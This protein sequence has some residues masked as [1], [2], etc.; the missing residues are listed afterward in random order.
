VL[1]SRTEI[2]IRKHGC[3]YRYMVQLVNLAARYLSAPL[4]HNAVFAVSHFS[5]IIC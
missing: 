3:H 1:A 4:L 5:D 2:L